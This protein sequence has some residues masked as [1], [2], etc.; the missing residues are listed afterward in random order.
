LTS[1]TKNYF[2]ETY[3]KRTSFALLF[4][5]MYMEVELTWAI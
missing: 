4:Q 5:G 3:F 2:S 1:G